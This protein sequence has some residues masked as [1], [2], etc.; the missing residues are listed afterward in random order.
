M[1]FC[2]GS[3]EGVPWEFMGFSQRKDGYG[4]GKVLMQKM[5]TVQKVGE[6]VGL[7]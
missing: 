7:E 6:W 3:G 5:A 2:W 1:W 4:L